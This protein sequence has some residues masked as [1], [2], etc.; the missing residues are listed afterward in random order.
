MQLL[1]FQQLNHLE[2]AQL[3]FVICLCFIL[4]ISSALGQ[5]HWRLGLIRFTN[6]RLPQSLLRCGRGELKAHFG[7]GFSQVSTVRTVCCWEPCFLHS[8]LSPQLSWFLTVAL[9]RVGL[10]CCPCPALSLCTAQQEGS[11]FSWKIGFDFSSV[12][13]VLVLLPWA[14]STG[15]SQRGE[16]SSLF[17]AS[18]EAASEES[19]LCCVYGAFGEQPL[20]GAVDWGE[21]LWAR[22]HLEGHDCSCG[23]FLNDYG[24]SSISCWLTSAKKCWFKSKWSKAWNI[25]CKDKWDNSPRL[26][27]TYNNLHHWWRFC[28]CMAEA[29]GECDK[30]YLKAQP[31]PFCVA[32]CARILFLWLS[33][34]FRLCCSWQCFGSYCMGT[35]HFNKFLKINISRW[36][37]IVTEM[38]K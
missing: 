18:E 4:T 15:T 6:Q 3:D 13:F 14:Q 34:I 33:F 25:D 35:G 5:R 37:F 38:A 12:L 8:W 9:R 28:V 2:P 31:S 11:P 19:C 20:L 36:T 21:H 10:R 17:A 7:C 29:K 26:L 23:I 1:N 22:W 24:L 32:L 27:N 16:C 30:K